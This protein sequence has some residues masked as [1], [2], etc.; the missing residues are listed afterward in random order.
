[1][2]IRRTVHTFTVRDPFRLVAQ[3]LRDRTENGG[4][5]GPED[6]GS[7]PVDLGTGQL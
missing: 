7:H 6:R 1:V 3:Q 4:S 2:G 5:P